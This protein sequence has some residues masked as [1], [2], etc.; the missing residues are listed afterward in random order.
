LDQYREYFDDRLRQFSCVY[1]GGYADTREH[2]PSKVFLKK[3]HPTNLPVV[4]ACE[5]CNNGFSGDEAYV[6]C[7]LGAGIS[8]STDPDQVSRVSIAK[9][10][11][12]WPSLRERI[13]RARFAHGGVVGYCVEIDRLE[14][15][16]A[17][18]ACGHVLFEVGKA[19]RRKPGVVSWM[20][21]DQMSLD[22]Q[23]E[24]D[25]IELVGSINEVGTRQTQRLM[26]I[27][28]EMQSSSGERRSG[29]VVVN[30]WLDVQEGTYRYQVREGVAAIEVRIVIWEYLVAQVIWD[31]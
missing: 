11:R 10:L 9:L 25:S 6:A 13:E 14:R 8:G 4:A 5:S 24:F 29:G 1:C 21:R 31:L 17:K 7:L 19:F 3:P 30:D 16:L 23:N 28:M 12:R 27:S 2:V 18:L 20:L 22:D 15:M 26:V